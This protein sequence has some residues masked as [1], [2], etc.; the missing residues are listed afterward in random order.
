M[1]GLLIAV[2]ALAAAG[3][4]IALYLL[5]VPDLYPEQE[6][7]LLLSKTFPIRL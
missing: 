5:L 2:V 3:V 6:P 1:A 4:L 7:L